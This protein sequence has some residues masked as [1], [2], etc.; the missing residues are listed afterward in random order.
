[1]PHQCVRCAKIYGDG[2]E[3]ILKGC[4]C[5][6]KLFFFLKKK[7]LDSAKRLV[8]SRLSEEDK[9]QIEQDV[10]EMV[11]NKDP[12]APVIL[13]FETIRVL[14]PGKYEIDLIQL[15]KGEPLVFK[16]EDGKYIIDL[17]ETFRRFQRR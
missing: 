11:G 1:M 12:G 3:E 14:T 16:L 9:N 17:P 5:G 15:F 7:N 10:I 6:A 8:E 4:T 2:A 13:D